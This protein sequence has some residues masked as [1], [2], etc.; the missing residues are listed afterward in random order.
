MFF[1][2]ATMLNP[3]A[4]GTAYD[5]WALAFDSLGSFLLLSLHVF[6]GRVHGGAQIVPEKNRESFPLSK[7]VFWCCLRMILL[8][9]Y[10]GVLLDQLQTPRPCSEA[11]VRTLSHKAGFIVPIDGKD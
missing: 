2:P 3:K 7:D 8:A 6:L 11:S 4:L 10:L 9:E 1:V 5:F